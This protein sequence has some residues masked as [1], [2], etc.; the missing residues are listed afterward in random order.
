MSNESERRSIEKLISTEHRRLD[1]VF[2]EVLAALTE[3]DEPAAAHEAFARLREQLERH[4]AQEDRLYYPALRALRP[5]H[6]SA[7][8]AIASAHE[9]LRSRLDAIAASAER[10]ALEEVRGGVEALASAFGAHESAEERL[11][12]QL[13]DELRSEVDPSGSR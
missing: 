13:D 1:S 9:V 12:H 2:A 10:G 5:A 4:L 7:L 8:L 11:L 3:G 6:R